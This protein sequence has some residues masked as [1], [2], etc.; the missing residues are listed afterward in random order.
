M[1]SAYLGGVSEVWRPFLEYLADRPDEWVPWPDL[2]EHIERTP[3]EA[4]GMLGA[5]ERRCGGLPPYEKRWIGR[6]RHFRMPTSADEIV[7]EL[8]DEEEE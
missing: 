7:R 2:C 6:T 8:R 1:R 5:A 3:Q 4:S